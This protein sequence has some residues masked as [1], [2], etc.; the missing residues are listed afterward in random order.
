MLN[1]AYVLS[2][3]FKIAVGKTFCLE[4]I[5][6]DIEGIIQSNVTKRISL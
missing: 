5:E 2:K 4:Q 6:I 1:H 3:P